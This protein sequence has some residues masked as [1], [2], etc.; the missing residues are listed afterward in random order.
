MYAYGMDINHDCKNES[1]KMRVYME[2]ECRYSENY[3][4]LDVL[5]RVT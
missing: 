2:E 5:L 1:K 3:F 4:F